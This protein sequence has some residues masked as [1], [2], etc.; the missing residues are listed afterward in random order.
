M[1]YINKCFI[2]KYLR[3]LYDFKCLILWVCYIMYILCI[4]VYEKKKG[5]KRDCYLIGRNKYIS[6][7]NI[8]LKD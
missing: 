2:F 3:Y 8:F 7:F 4:G 6:N 1:F 5:E